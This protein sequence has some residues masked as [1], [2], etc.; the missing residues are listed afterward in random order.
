MVIIR[1]GVDYA[2][3]DIQDGWP[4][5][6]KQ[7]QRDEKN[8]EGVQGKAKGHRILNTLQLK[9]RGREASRPVVC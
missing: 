7:Q 3:C 2:W 4:H 8:E 6:G 1:C 5:Q 9:D